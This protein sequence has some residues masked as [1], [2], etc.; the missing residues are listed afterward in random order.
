[1]RAEGPAPKG[2]ENSA[3]GFNPGNPQNK[4]VALKGRE[5]RLPDGSRHCRAKVNKT[6]LQLD[7]WARF[8]RVRKFDLAH[9]SGRIALGGRFPG[10]KP[11]ADALAPAGQK[12]KVYSPDRNVFSGIR[13]HVPEGRRD[14]SLARSAWNSATQK[15]RPVGH[16]VIRMRTDSMF[17]ATKFWD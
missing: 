5:M 8:R 16:G 12:T 9:P 2:L 3:Q 14:R 11:W 7:H 10:L 17:G 13:P 4:R 1:M 6:N 15:H